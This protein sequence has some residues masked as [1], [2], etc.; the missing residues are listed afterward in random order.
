MFSQPSIH[1]GESV[2]HRL[3]SKYLRTKHR[4][5]MAGS[6]YFGYINV[7]SFSIAVLCSS[8]KCNVCIQII[9]IIEMMYSRRT[10]IFKALLWLLPTIFL[11]T[12]A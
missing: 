12:Q 3:L 10:Y 9:H 11:A 5:P 2:E 4:R 6:S 8:F 1:V 7:I